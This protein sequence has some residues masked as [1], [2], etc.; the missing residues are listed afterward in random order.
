MQAS[1]GRHTRIASSRKFGCG[2]SYL[3]HSAR[4]SQLRCVFEIAAFLHS[5]P[6][7]V[8]PKLFIRPEV[9]KIRSHRPR[10]F[11]PQATQTQHTRTP[12]KQVSV[13]LDRVP[14][15]L[16]QPPGSRQPNLS[17]NPRPT[18]FGP[19]YLLLSI[20]TF[21]IFFAIM[22]LEGLVSVFVDGAVV[23]LGGYLNLRCTGGE[24]HADP[25]S[26]AA[27]GRIGSP[28]SRP[29]PHVVVKRLMPPQEGHT[30]NVRPNPHEVEACGHLP[31]VLPIHRSVAAGASSLHRHMTL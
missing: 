29:K 18:I 6:P 3:P 23:F 9:T 31:P 25:P 22:L 30:L 28:D 15:A 19:T 14:Q 2:L 16:V 27:L 5:R 21:L 13:T 12:P 24:F 1:G 10:T 17:P 11:K 8:R 7:G 20:A 26:V 4:V